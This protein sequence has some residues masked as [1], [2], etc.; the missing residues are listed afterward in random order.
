MFTGVFYLNENVFFKNNVDVLS[1]NNFPS[2]T[3]PPYK[4]RFVHFL[5]SYFLEKTTFIN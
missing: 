3:S 5:A 4:Q 1:Y 2:P